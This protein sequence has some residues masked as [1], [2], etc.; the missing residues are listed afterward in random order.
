VRWSDV[1]LEA[2]EIGPP[3]VEIRRALVRGRF[4]VPKTGKGRSVAIP[5]S[6]VDVLAELL[7]ARRREGLKRGWPEVPELVFCSETGGPLDAR[8]VVRS[9]HRVRRLAKAKG[10]RSFKLHVAR[11]TY[12]SLALAAGK[13]VRWV[14]GQLGHADPQLTLRTY[15]HAMR[16]EEADLSFADFAAGGTK[17]HPRGT[18]PESPRE[19]RRA[20]V[21]R[22]RVRSRKVVTRARFER[23]TPSFGGWC[24]IQAEL[25]GR[26]AGNYS[27]VQRYATSR[28]PRGMGREPA[29]PLRSW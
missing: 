18:K 20:S 13:S 26:G 16:E 5:P 24:S 28:H 12:A 8:N 15:A 19:A 1:Q 11:H 27:R 21:A 6:L 17:R 2:S 10:V 4:G 9:W 23:A 3:R 14:A 29:R 22:A 7:D 25:P